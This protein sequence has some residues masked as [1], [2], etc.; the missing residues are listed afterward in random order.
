MKSIILIITALTVISILVYSCSDGKTVE[1]KVAEAEAKTNPKNSV[2]PEEIKTET[3]ILKFGNKTLEYTG[4]YLFSLN[5]EI[6]KNM[7]A[8]NPG[9]VA[10]E[11]YKLMTPPSATIGLSYQKLSEKTNMQGAI[12]GILNGYDNIDG[13]KIIEENLE[14]V[15]DRYGFPAKL[16]TGKM[17]ILNENGGT[18]TGEFKN[19]FID[20]KNEIWI[21]QGIFESVDSDEMNA[22]TTILNSIKISK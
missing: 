19:L 9:L 14:D 7:K 20:N 18:D 3:R 21:V 4:K 2:Q 13:V 11:Y 15:S 8:A 16:S 5:P 10:M 12:D 17:Q 22:Y 1:Q 6:S